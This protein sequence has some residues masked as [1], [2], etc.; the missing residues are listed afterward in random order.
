M[1]KYSGIV[2][3]HSCLV[4]GGIRWLSLQDTRE[5]FGPQL[6]SPVGLA[7]TPIDMPKSLTAGRSS[8]V[9]ANMGSSCVY[10]IA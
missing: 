8:I 2:G 10:S 4:G 1:K 9:Q 5:G 7:Q 3:V 6:C